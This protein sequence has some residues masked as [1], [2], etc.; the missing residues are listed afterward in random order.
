M[1]LII[2][3][4]KHIKLSYHFFW[5]GSFFWMRCG[6]LSPATWMTLFLIWQRFVFGIPLMMMLLGMDLKDGIAVHHS[7][8]Y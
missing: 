7:I 6:T 3:H 8:L 1:S 2:K 5:V 4:I